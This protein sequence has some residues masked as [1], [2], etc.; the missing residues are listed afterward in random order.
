MKNI[1]DSFMGD[2]GIIKIIDDISDQKDELISVFDSKSHSHKDISRY[3][4]LLARTYTKFNQYPSL[5]TQL[6]NVLILIK[7]VKKEKQGSKRQ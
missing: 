2:V 6:M 3:S 5:V 7:N 1:K 4:L